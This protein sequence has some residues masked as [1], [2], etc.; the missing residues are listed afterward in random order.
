ML[1]I[2]LVLSL[3]QQYCL[4]PTGD[5][6]VFAP[7]R[8]PR[9]NRFGWRSPPSGAFF[10]LAPASGAGMGTAC[11]CAAVTDVYGGAITWTRGSAGECYSNDGQTLTQCGNNLPRVSSGSLAST[12]IGPWYES[13][14]TNLALWSR[15]LSNAAWVKTSVTCTLTATGMRNDAN[16]ASACTATGAAGTVLQTITTAAATRSTSFHVKRVSGSGTIEVTRDNGVTWSNITAS[17]SSVAWKRVV[18]TETLGCTGGNCIVVAAMTGSVLNPVIGFRIGTSGDVIAVDFVQDEDAAFSTSPIL[19]TSVSATRSADISTSAASLTA[20]ASAGCAA[21]TVLMSGQAAPA[22][23]IL[24]GDSAG[25]YLYLNTTLRV[26]DGTTEPTL[27]AGLVAGTAKRY[28]STWTGAT[29]SLFNVT[30]ST[31]NTGAFDGAMAT[32]GPLRIGSGAI[33]GTTGNFVLKSIQLDPSPT[34]CQ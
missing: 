4:S 20:L 26:F 18:S 14:Q 25:R 24:V 2:V 21:A 22:A 8:G 13:Q 33:V 23:E 1:G 16:Q 10:E 11:A 28:R 15:D 31:T 30:D 32:T 12:Q 3:G 6:D 27:S 29:Q 5:C 19:T 17:L 34:R 7:W 9:P